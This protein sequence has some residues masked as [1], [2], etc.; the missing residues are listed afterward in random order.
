[1]VAAAV[2]AA[3]AERTRFW[4]QSSYEEF[5]RGTARGVALRSDGRLVLAPRFTQFA[6]P[7]AAYLW[8]LR[9]DSKGRLYAAGGS[10]AKVLRL[11]E[12]GA[13]TVFESQEMAA[14]ALAV[15]AQDNL[16]VG[17]SP[18]GKVY[19]VTPAGESSVFFEPKTKY[20]WDL[21]IDSAGTLYVATG[22]KGE[23][24]A[25]ARDG[26]AQSFYKSEE[27]H[28]RALAFDARGN[29]VVGTDPNGLIV[30]VE[31]T[32]AETRGF[33]LHESAKREITALV[34]DRSGNL[35]AAAIGDKGR[36]Q[37]QPPQAQPQPV[38][39]QQQPGAV[40]VQPQPQVTTFV[41]F[42]QTTGGSDVYRI[43]PDGAPE[44]IWSSRDDLVYSLALS[45]AGRL[46]MGTGNKGLVLQLEENS[47]FS[48]LGKTSSA[49]VTTLVPGPG[50]RVLVGTS[51]PGKV[52]ALGPDAEPEGT[53]ESQ[54]FDAKVFSQWGRLNWWGENGAA[55]GQVAFYV[56]TGNTSNPEK[57]WGA[58][59]GP[60][61]MAGSAATSCPPARFAQW[62]AV[63]KAGK[64]GAPNIS[65]VSLAYL[66]KN[67]AP[68]IEGIVLQNP[69][70]RVQGFSAQP[71]AQQ[72]TVQLRLPPPVAG[73][74]GAAPQPQQPQQ[75][76]FEA[77]PQGFV[78]RGHQAVL[79]SA[80]DE[81]EDELSYALYFRAE[82][83]QNW[84][85]LKDKLEQRFHSWD[86]NTMPDGAYYLKIVASDAASNPPGEG[87]SASRISD[88]FEVDNTP[89]AIQ[90]V[91]HR[92]TGPETRVQ[93]DA[94]D[95]Y[96]ILTRAE[97]SLNAG[98][99]MLVFPVDRTSDS[100]Q[101]SYEIVL[102]DLPP[103]EHTITVRVFDQFENSAAEKLTF[104]L[105]AGKK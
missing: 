43:G 96:S 70:V 37:P 9:V 57:N 13:T 35:Y 102:R 6:D 34:T 95:S 49:Q 59:C 11:D 45:P 60:Y 94:R 23:V 104:T 68:S 42:P 86:T 72:Q 84:R 39:P 48:S 63:F 51:N 14:Q 25:V 19:K 78:Q 44:Q 90:N 5:D 81:N 91:R 88:R 62:R 56:R 47:V 103:G 8:A 7:N 58:W 54:T 92:A 41:P 16:Y 10:N 38:A 15:D 97:F 98:D 18:D 53:Y 1:M 46:L 65:W 4:R 17:T 26:K 36:P 85:L 29:L 89:P 55:N 100:A 31:K 12:K 52:F 101:E 80:R 32:A 22:D 74:P 24:F 93:F 50:G 69:N 87:L 79:W 28:V 73:G 82:G 77:P 40:Q 27:A 71:G 61:T 30:R 64:D 3:R 105:P 20:I 67:V 66:P 83:E 75:P 21:A 33:V 2:M 76:R 99:W